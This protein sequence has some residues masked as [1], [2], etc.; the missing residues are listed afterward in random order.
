MSIFNEFNNFSITQYLYRNKKSSTMLCTLAYLHFVVFF[1]RV[2]L[3]MFFTF[4]CYNSVLVFV[5][6]FWLSKMFNIISSSN[7]K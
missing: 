3:C 2:C 5:G 4:G 6:F 1:I 7:K